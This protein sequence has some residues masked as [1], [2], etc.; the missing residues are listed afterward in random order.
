MVVASSGKVVISKPSEHR[1]G[2]DQ[3]CL[4]RKRQLIS[5]EAMLTHQG[6][7]AI[8]GISSTDGHTPLDE[9]PLKDAD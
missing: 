9:L 6:I 1:T 8:T 7:E 5:G 2:G 3:R 4:I